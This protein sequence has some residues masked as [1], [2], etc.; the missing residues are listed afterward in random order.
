MS[1]GQRLP[2]T[3]ATAVAECNQ[4]P[5]M[6]SPLPHVSCNFGAVEGATDICHGPLSLLSGLPPLRLIGLSGTSVPGGV[7]L[8]PIGGWLTLGAGRLPVWPLMV[9]FSVGDTAAGP[10]GCSL[11][12][13][14]PAASTVIN[15]M[16][17]VAAIK[18]NRVSVTV[19][20]IRVPLGG[21]IRSEVTFPRCTSPP[22]KPWLFIRC[23]VGTRTPSFET[24][25]TW[26]VTPLRSDTLSVIDPTTN[27]PRHQPVPSPAAGGR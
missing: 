26:E 19:R 3:I 12:G 18:P 5:Q 4:A 17:D 20:G 16:A 13:V 8:G 23:P 14:Q 6:G 22:A 1:V 21:L 2:A 25:C 27:R 15:A 24:F 11:V 7:R 9:P 10:A